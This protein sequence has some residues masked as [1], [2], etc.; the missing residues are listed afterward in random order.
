MHEIEPSGFCTIHEYRQFFEKRIQPSEIS[1]GAL[2]LV[3]ADIRAGRKN[4]EAFKFPVRA[5]A[6][7]EKGLVAVSVTVDLLN[8]DLQPIEE[9]DFSMKDGVGKKPGIQEASTKQSVREM[10]F[11]DYDGYLDIGPAETD[12]EQEIYIPELMTA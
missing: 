6:I 1:L 2:Y 5:K 10:Y 9:V 12:I 11:R 8:L 3:L 7:G 4:Q